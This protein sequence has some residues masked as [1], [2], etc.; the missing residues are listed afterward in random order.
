MRCPID[1][2]DLYEK[3]FSDALTH[4]CGSCHGVFLPGKLFRDVMAQAAMHAH[5][6]AKPKNTAVNKY[7]RFCPA[8]CSAM[9]TLTVREIEIE[10]C[11]DCMG[12]WLDSG[13][14][15]KMILQYGL[16]GKQALD[17]IG[18][19]LGEVKQQ[20]HSSANSGAN[21]GGSSD[22]LDVFDVVEIA[23]DMLNIF[24]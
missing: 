9:M 24:N 8:K 19:N 14:L 11:P 15:E 3:T 6:E 23:V 4:R 2:S 7:Q 20:V 22:N 21:K 13:E 16:P 10:V 17:K 5:H 18:A 12:I 1:H